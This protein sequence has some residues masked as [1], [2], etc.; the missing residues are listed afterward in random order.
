ML[1]QPASKLRTYSLMFFDVFQSQSHSVD[2]RVHHQDI[3]VQATR[4]VYK[5]WWTV[6]TNNEC[7]LFLLECRKLMCIFQPARVWKDLPWTE[8]IMWRCAPLSASQK[9]YLRHVGKCARCLEILPWRFWIWANSAT[10]RCSPSLESW[11]IRGIIPKWPNI[12]G[13]WIIILD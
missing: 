8:Q 4:H 11:L 6:K 9:L 2:L 10:G 5:P 3:W 7:F 1:V 13:E 12:S